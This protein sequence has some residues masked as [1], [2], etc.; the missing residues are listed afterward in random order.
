M[1]TRF[2]NRLNGFKLGV[3]LLILLTDVSVAID[4]DEGKYN[5][6]Y[7]L[8]ETMSPAE[9]VAKVDVLSKSRDIEKRG[10]AAQ[11]L[12]EYFHWLQPKKQRNIILQ[13][14]YS[15]PTSDIRACMMLACENDPSII[16]S[17]S[18]AEIIRITDKLRNDPDRDTRR[19]AI[20]EGDKI[21][22]EM[23][24]KES[25]KLKH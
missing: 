1:K 7:T 22:E 5:A 16:R 8:F 6:I 20:Q 13:R 11:L 19:W 14:L 18:D 10:T 21:K 9:V 23:K 24:E 17:L 15:D 3:I 12:G 2:W 4:V 25:R